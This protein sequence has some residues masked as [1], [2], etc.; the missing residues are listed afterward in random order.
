MEPNRPGK[1]SIH[2][3]HSNQ[4]D[5]YVEL[6]IEDTVSGCIASI[7]QLQIMDFGEAVLGRGF[8]DCTF[9]LNES[10]VIGKKRELRD[11]V[12]PCPPLSGP[13]QTKEYA[14]AWINKHAA[15]ELIDGWNPH[16]WNDV[17]NS[18][19]WVGDKKVRVGLIRFVANE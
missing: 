8:V 18:H 17:F 10:G 4:D 3:V 7:A 5:G 6:R 19:R 1:L 15:K 2:R 11:I 12:I 9:Q 13:K 14:L 16:S